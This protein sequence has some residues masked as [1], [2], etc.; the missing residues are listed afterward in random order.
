M[1]AMA[2]I[3]LNGRSVLY[4]AV[5][6]CLSGCVAADKHLSDVQPVEGQRLTIAAAQSIIS[7]MSGAEVID[8][9]G[10]PNILSTDKEGREVWVYD[11]VSTQTTFSNSSVGAGAG[12][13]GVFDS[14]GGA[15]AGVLG[16]EGN[17]S[18]GATATTQRSLSVVVRFDHDK[19]VESV[20]YRASRF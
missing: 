4:A 15:I 10:A 17:R 9:L 6:V 7:G 5:I 8:K 2:T 16:L 20:A 18:A 1:I 11:K 14:V 3:K 12:A 13:G 19:A